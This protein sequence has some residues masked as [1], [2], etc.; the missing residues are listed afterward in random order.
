VDYLH[1]SDLAGDPVEQFARWFAEA[2]AA[3]EPEPEA[4]ALATA[5]AAGHP[6]VR[7][8]LMRRFDERGWGFYTNSRSR[9]GFEMSENGWA[10]LAFRWAKVARQVRI[11]GPV[12]RLADAEADAYFASRARE[13]QIGAW[14]STQSDVLTDRAELQARYDE[15]DRRFQDSPVERPAWWGGYLVRPAEVEFWQQGEFRLHDRIRYLRDGSRWRL[16]RLYP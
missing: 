14:A 3:G 6:S 2:R 1:I 4:M 5:G 7:Y 15:F 9:K 12:S 10:A 13:S 8:V 16:E 11:S